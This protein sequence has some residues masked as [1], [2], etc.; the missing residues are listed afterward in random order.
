MVCCCCHECTQRQEMDDC[1][2]HRI[3]RG[4]LRQ[5]RQG[6]VLVWFA[7]YWEDGHR[8]GKTIGKVS[9]LSKTQAQTALDK[10]LSP[11][12]E[13]ATNNKENITFERFVQ[14]IALPIWS[15]RWK[16]STKGTTEDRI[17]RHLITTLGEREL[18]TIHRPLLQELLD[19]KGRT[20]MSKAVLHH[21]RWDLKMLFRIALAEGLIGKNPAELL[22]PTGGTQRERHVMTKE[23]LTQVLTTFDL[24]ERLILKL[25]GIAGMRPGEA[26]ALQWA[27]HTNDGLRITRRIY[28]SIIDT[29]K[30]S[31]SVR[32]VT[33]GPSTRT[34]LET[35][36]SLQRNTSPNAWV[37]PSETG[38]TPLSPS[39]HW[40]RHLR[41]TLLTMGLGWVSFQVL[42]RTCS[43]L[44][45]DLGADGKLVS[46]QLG[47]TLDVNQNVYTKV[48]LDR[49]IAAVTM[50]D[51]AVNQPMESS[52]VL[53]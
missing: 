41:P 22:Y 14:Q 9:E 39:N 34:D 10:I 45:N 42:R 19:Q 43:S 17:Q 15:R 46:Q 37:F 11:I 49:Q 28:R 2:Q 32:L 50:L 29:P 7:T 47:H 1:M 33:L 53:Q 24:R 18:G 31:L 3:Q 30:S 27:D 26:Y 51:Q 13:R 38:K 36:R 52:G 35:W 5:R 40:R 44:L 48:G 23:E 16:A 8:R 4:S 21:L 6:R 20:T 25:T 12:N